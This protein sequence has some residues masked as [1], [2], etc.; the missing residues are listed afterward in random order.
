MKAMRA[1]ELV[2]PKMEKCVRETK[3]DVR[4]PAATS[5]EFTKTRDGDV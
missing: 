1:Y 5:A 4:R 3:K 2:E